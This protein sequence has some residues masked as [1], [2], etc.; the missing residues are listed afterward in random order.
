[1]LHSAATCGRRLIIQ[2]PVAPCW[3]FGWLTHA[4]KLTRP[5]F[6]PA[7]KRLGRTVPAR[8]HASRSSVFVNR[9]G[10]RA[11]LPQPRGPW[12]RSLVRALCRRGSAPDRVLATSTTMRASRLLHGDRAQAALPTTSARKRRPS[13]AGRRRLY[14]PYTSRAVPREGT[15]ANLGTQRRTSGFGCAAQLLQEA[16]SGPF[17]A[18]GAEAPLSYRD[19]R[20]HAAC[21]SL[22]PTGR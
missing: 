1:M 10:W 15:V 12:P 13:G 7:L 2:R 11:A 5:G 6:G 14:M 20:R 19:E 4:Q 21:R 17:T 9:G 3:L 22:P 18:P 8:R 16:D